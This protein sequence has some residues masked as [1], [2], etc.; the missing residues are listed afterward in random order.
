[1]QDWHI[2]LILSGI[3]FYHMQLCRN[4]GH[5]RTVAGIER[6]ASLQKSPQRTL[7]FHGFLQYMATGHDLH[8]SSAFWSG[9]EWKPGGEYLSA[10][11]DDES[12]RNFIQT[13]STQD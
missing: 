4:C 1:M 13:L 11:G 9:R 10:L 12:T 7:D 8:D 6:P 5:G 3:I 2:S